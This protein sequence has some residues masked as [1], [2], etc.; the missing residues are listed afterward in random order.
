M[1]ATLEDG[2][3]P[4]EVA[5]MLATL[6][7]ATATWHSVEIEGLPPIL[8]AA[9]PSD[10]LWAQVLEPEL[11]TKE[12]VDAFEELSRLLPEEARPPEEWV[13]VW[14]EA[15]APLAAAR[16]VLTHGDVH[17]TQI[18]VGSD[19]EV[20]TVID[21]DHSG[22]AHPVR[23]FNFGEW[24]FGI[25]RWEERFD[26]LYEAYWEPYRAARDA[27]LPDHRSVLLFHVLGDAVGLAGYVSRTPDS[28]FH[29]QRLR[30]CLDHLAA[31]SRSL[32]DG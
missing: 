18:L 29:L 3:S 4:D 6:G 30:H 20:T 7:E 24:G 16:R 9:P 2:L 8:E 28:W 23:D 22:V 27:K 25:F 26:V 15:L 19:L 32:H 14:E 13:G 17:E 1:Y 12:L 5:R 31:T 10:A 21:W 11:C